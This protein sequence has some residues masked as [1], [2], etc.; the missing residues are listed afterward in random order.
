MP[1]TLQQKV[2]IGNHRRG[3]SQQSTVRKKWR[4]YNLSQYVA[5][6]TQPIGHK[7]S[8]ISQKP[9]QTIMF[10]LRLKLLELFC[11]LL[12]LSSS[13]CRIPH[14]LHNVACNKGVFHGRAHL[15]Q[16]SARALSNPRWRPNM[17]TKA[18]LAPKKYAT[19]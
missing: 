6:P 13:S 1:Y 14:N 8:R 19:R 11:S 16:P 10:I 15:L 4:L 5:N 9:A 7:E 12:W 3:E 2:F 18:A 17:R